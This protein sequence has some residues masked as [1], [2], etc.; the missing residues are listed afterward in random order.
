VVESAT[1][2]WENLPAKTLAIGVSWP[3]LLQ[4]MLWRY[5]NTQV[6]QQ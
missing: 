1:A 4:Q 5:S 2:D 6:I 3:L